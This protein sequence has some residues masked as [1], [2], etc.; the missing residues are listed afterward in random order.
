T[1]GILVEGNDIGTSRNGVTVS[2]GAHAN[3]IG[4]TVAGARNLIW[5]NSSTAIHLS[6]PGTKS[7]LVEGNYIG[8]DATGTARR[9][10][11]AGVAID[12][13]AGSN[14]IGGTTAAARNLISGNG[15]GVSIDGSG[16]NGNVVE[17][18]YIGTDATGAG[19]LGNGAGVSIGDGA[20][21]NRIGGTT[22]AA[23]NVVSGNQN[24]GIGVAGTRNVVEGNYIGVD[25]TGAHVL[26]NYYGVS[27]GGTDNTIGGTAPGA[28]DVI[29]GSID[30]GVDIF[31][32]TG[33]VVAGNR[34][35]TDASG[36][37]QLGNAADGIAICAS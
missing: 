23:R 21:G 19:H 36:T 33:V 1:T 5:G 25:V 30:K 27:V 14:P 11:G 16:T 3:T 2:G 22:A 35:G 12:G 20:S 34:I 17:G 26:F 37:F 28:G 9:P 29:S 24:L 4:G 18:N 7:N 10:N 13:G 31:V 6:G 8:T 32:A 15:G